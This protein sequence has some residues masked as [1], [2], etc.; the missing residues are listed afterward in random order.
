MAYVHRD[1]FLFFRS[2]AAH[3]LRGGNIV[4][5]TYFVGSMIAN[6]ALLPLVR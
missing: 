2:I 6:T 4:R 5:N 3:Q 1:Q